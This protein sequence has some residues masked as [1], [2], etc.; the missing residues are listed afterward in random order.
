MVG[1]QL[2]SPSTTFRSDQPQDSLD[3]HLKVHDELSSRI[4]SLQTSL[5]HTF[6][7]VIASAIV[8]VL[9]AVPDMSKNW[10]VYLS[11][12]TTL[13]I[14]FGIWTLIAFL[15]FMASNIFTLCI[16]LGFRC[17]M[18]E[19]LAGRHPLPYGEVDNFIPTVQCTTLQ[20]ISSYIYYPGLVISGFVHRFFA[21][22]FT[23]TIA[24]VIIGWST[25]FTLLYV[26]QPPPP[27]A[28]LYQAYVVIAHNPW[29]L[30]SVASLLLLLACW[31]VIPQWLPGT[32]D[33]ERALLDK[34]FVVISETLSHLNGIEVVV[35]GL[36]RTA[37]RM[38]REVV[39]I[40]PLE[41][42]GNIIREQCQQNNVPLVQVPS[43]PTALIGQPDFRLGIPLF[44]STLIS[45]RARFIV[46]H[47]FPGTLGVVALVIARSRRKK[48]ILFQHIYL[49]RFVEC[50]PIAGRSRFLKWAMRA[51]V[52]KFSN[53]CDAVIVP[54]NFM[55]VEML[56][57]G[58]DKG[59][60]RIVPTGV[61]PF[62]LEKPTRGAVESMKV[63]LSSPLLLYAGRLS[64]EKNLE[65]L[66]VAFSIVLP[67]YPTARLVLAGHG[68]SQGRLQKLAR[69]LD[70]AVTF[71]GHLGWDKLRTLY[72]A[73]D[74]FCMPSAGE[75]Q[76]LAILEAKACAR[77]CVVVD[78][79]GAAEQIEDGVDGL[80]VAGR[81]LQQDT[82][83][84]FAASIDKVL[85]DPTLAATL[86][87]EARRRAR[88]R[89]CEVSHRELLAFLDGI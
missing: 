26:S 28:Q 65:M 64:Q 50:V 37:R 36:V 48:V 20:L 10:R 38:R 85:S 3:F 69:R 52:G 43:F 23:A 51:L 14:I 59:R 83:K 30:P 49:E 77:P 44:L 7:I 11:Y 70:C 45:D 53:L 8:G 71:M 79:A 34:E 55:A 82:A 13:V 81:D 58:V 39:L 78:R 21:M 33:V 31:V 15:I 41:A 66:L 73:A 9:L 76:G 75:S 1:H 86:A 47:G 63:A 61:D 18:I 2:D 35:L 25:T 5:F 72:W 57:C 17:L 88:K 42:G 68:P 27:Q 6:T 89:T 4:N 22:L 60:L 16:I 74:V 87:R 46:I 40:G 84:A 67:K 12:P 29:L 32:R 24:C 54:S 19:N 56:R 62:L 80:L